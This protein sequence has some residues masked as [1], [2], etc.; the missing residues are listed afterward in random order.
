MRHC[1]ELKNYDFQSVAQP[2]FFRFFSRFD[3]HTVIRSFVRLFIG[4]VGRTVAAP[5]HMA[6]MT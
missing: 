2:R 5:F 6:M 4:T 1:A 3:G